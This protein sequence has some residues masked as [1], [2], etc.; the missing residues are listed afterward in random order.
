MAKLAEYINNELGYKI[1][2]VSFLSGRDDRVAQDILDIISKTS[3]NKNE[4]ITGEYLTPNGI[5]NVINHASFLVG[6]RLHSIIYAI[7]TGT[8][9]VIIDYSSKVRGMVE[10]N[11]LSEYSVDINRMDVDSLKNRIERMI[12]SEKEYEEILQEQCRIMKEK[13]KE[14]KRLMDEL[15]KEEII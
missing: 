7:C 14:N 8:P 9:M 6:M 13:E 15:M 11:R 12:A 10:L 5:I 1:V 4:L 2:F 3:E